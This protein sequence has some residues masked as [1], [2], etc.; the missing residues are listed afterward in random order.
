MFEGEDGNDSVSGM[1][2]KLNAN[3]RRRY[4]SSVHQGVKV[5]WAVGVRVMGLGV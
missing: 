1:A 4:G 5:A 2:H 3:C